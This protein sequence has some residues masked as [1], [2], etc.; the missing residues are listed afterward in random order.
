M[1]KLINY[2]G[3][4]QAAVDLLKRN[5]A[6]IQYDGRNGTFD[7]LPTD[8]QMSHL[9]GGEAGLGDTRIHRNIIFNGHEVDMG[10]SDGRSGQMCDQLQIVR[11]VP[12]LSQMEDILKS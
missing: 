9:H 11:M 2:G 8:C 5:G 6:Q 12:D 3:I 4:Q 10:V 1:L 7:R